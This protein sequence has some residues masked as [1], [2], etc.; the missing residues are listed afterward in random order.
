[1]TVALM[2]RATRVCV[3]ECVSVFVRGGNVCQ[4]VKREADQPL[5][6]TLTLTDLRLRDDCG[7]QY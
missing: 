6:L 4:Y 7:H 3:Y 2:K 1:M 5:T